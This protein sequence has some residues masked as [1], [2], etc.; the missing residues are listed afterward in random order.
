M[1]ILAAILALLTGAAGWY[2]LFY[3]NAAHRLAGLEESHINRR[4]I[5]LRRINGL[6]MLL[7]AVCFFMLFWTVTRSPAILLVLVGVL[8]LLILI[9]VLALIDLRLT[10]RLRHQP[11]RSAPDQHR[12]PPEKQ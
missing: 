9:L 3:P 12:Q 8:L 11:P 6:A 2:Y 7:L 10:W 5:L 1:Q 4:R